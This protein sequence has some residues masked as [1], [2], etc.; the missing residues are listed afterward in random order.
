ML[1]PNREQEQERQ[2]NQA[3]DPRWGVPYEWL[4]QP[5]P[6][7][8]NATIRDILNAVKLVREKKENAGWALFYWSLWCGAVSSCIAPILM[9]PRPINSD[10]CAGMV[11]AALLLVPY[12]LT[13]RYIL[14]QIELP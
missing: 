6:G 9:S 13:H 2:G 14:K 8:D 7:T 10:P 3:I 4:N 12:W 1:E 5:V 11:V